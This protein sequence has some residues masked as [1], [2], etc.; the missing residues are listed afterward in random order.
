VSYQSTR[1]KA[2]THHLIL[3]LIFQ[4]KINSAF[5]SRYAVYSHSDNNT[6]SGCYGAR[7]GGMYARV[8]NFQS[9]VKMYVKLTDSDFHSAPEKG[10]TLSSGLYR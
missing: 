10:F 1:S 4:C 5:T 9:E 7:V 2:L 8:P 6:C 3:I